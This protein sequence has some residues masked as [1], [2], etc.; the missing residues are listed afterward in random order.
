MTGASPRDL[1]RAP[2]AALWSPLAVA[3]EGAALARPRDL[4]LANRAAGLAARAGDAPRLERVARRA[5]AAAADAPERLVLRPPQPP[6]WRALDQPRA[7][8]ALS[9]LQRAAAAADVL[10][11]LMFGALLG[12]RRDGRFIPGDGDIDL[13]I[14]GTDAA[15]RL[16]AGAAAAGLPGR[17]VRAGGPKALKFTHP[18]GTELDAKVLERDGAGVSWRMAVAGI[19]ITKRY[20]GPFELGEMEFLGQPVVAPRPAEAFLEWQYGPG[21]VR[22]DPGY[23]AYTSGPVHG[24]A[25]AAFMR[26][27]GAR[28]VLRAL[29]RSPAA[30]AARFARNLAGT[31]PDDPLWPRVAAAIA[32]APAPIEDPPAPGPAR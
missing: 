3:A 25:H 7:L 14:L 19:V 12:A 9:D 23:H 31:F 21:W 15:R 18:N 24:P 26:A 17:L 4:A 8:A 20:P 10:V 22:P 2:G 5:L 30:T 29:L 27:V 32:A 16:L 13:G 1:R 11:F 6:R 28:A